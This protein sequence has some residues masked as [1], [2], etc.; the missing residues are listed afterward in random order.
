MD[1]KQL[2]YFL[3][4]TEEMSITRAA[5]RLHIAQPHLS[6]QLKLLEDELG[7]K[8]VERNTR[9]LQITEAGLILQRRAAQIMELKDATN[10]E[11]SDFKKGLNGMLSIGTISTAGNT[12]LK[13]RI[14]QFHE[15][16]PGVSFQIRE[17]GT[18]NILELLKTG[19]V[20]IGIIRTPIAAEGFNMID[21]PD[22]PMVAATGGS[23]YWYSE[24]KDLTI[25]DLADVPLLI[26]PRYES[27][28]VESCNKAGFNPRIICESDDA[29]LILQWAKSGMGVAV[30]PMTWLNIIP[31]L[32]LQHFVLNE[33]ELVT[34]TAIIWVKKKYLS[35]VAK[36][37]LGLF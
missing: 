31:N 13:E 34:R 37:F 29:G 17:G 1:I 9:H 6:Q 20:E 27:V 7:V 24:R 11:L 30:I 14:C 10:R 5:E 2:D 15:N 22:E 4:I 25:A 28:I 32:E 8:L 35:P 18:Y 36:H 23:T 26:V 16:Y 21:L 3:K 12:L 19:V 33:A